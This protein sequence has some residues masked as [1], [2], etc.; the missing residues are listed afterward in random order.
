MGVHSILT[1]E[2]SLQICNRIANGESRESIC[3]DPEMPSRET[4]RAWLRQGDAKKAEI[5]EL[6]S[7]EY[8]RGIEDQ[9][10]SFFDQA[11]DIKAR[12]LL[13]RKIPNPDQPT[14]MII[15]PRFVDA[16]T[17]RVIIDTIKWE[18]GRRKPKVYGD[19]IDLAV[20]GDVNIT[21]KDNFK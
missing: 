8:A 16:H 17:G 11:A 13:P 14:E 18:A 15:N 10:D 12:M 19:K 20:S 6:F 2:L 21:V 3:R 7:V 9:A 5:Y 4:I 1:P